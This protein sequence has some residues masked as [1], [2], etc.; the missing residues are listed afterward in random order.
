MTWVLAGLWHGVSWLFLLYGLYHGVL[1][2]AT[3][4]LSRRFPTDPPRG[5]RRLAQ[6]MLTFYLVLMGYVLFRAR[7]LLTAA[8]FIVALHAPRAP[9]IVSRDGLATAAACAGALVFC[10]LLDH[11]V[12]QRR[13]AIERGFGLWPAIV[14]AV[15]CI[16][17]FSAPTQPFIYFAF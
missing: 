4:A 10:H 1:L 12:R 11:V 6:T 8:H 3:A 14:V 16:L 9:S 2:A 15:T 7:S 5:L 17:L 13:T